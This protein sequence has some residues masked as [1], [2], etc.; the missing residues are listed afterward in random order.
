MFRENP[1]D[2]LDCV[3]R[4]AREELEKM[5][6]RDKS[7]KEIYGVEVDFEKPAVGSVED[8]VLFRADRYQA[9]L[10][11]VP[12]QC[13]IEAFWH[14][15]S[16]PDTDKSTKEVFNI[17]F[18]EQVTTCTTHIMGE[19]LIRRK[20]SLNALAKRVYAKSSDNF[21]RYRANLKKKVLLPMDQHDLWHVLV[22]RE[23]AGKVVRLRS[24]P[25][26]ADTSDSVL[27]GGLRFHVQAGDVLKGFYDYMYTPLRRKQ[28]EALTRA[29][30]DIRVMGVEER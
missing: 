30:E 28:H 19:T 18:H 12:L 5:I 21:S 7:L 25:A 10:W 6:Q 22:K 11:G 20:L 24:N 13:W 1:S 27:A 4:K 16:K 23:D 2:R 26:L 9:M 29:L 8:F 15:F 17:V 3:A 14:V